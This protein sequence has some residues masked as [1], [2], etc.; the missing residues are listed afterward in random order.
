MAERG[1]PEVRLWKAGL[2]ER[3]QQLQPL[4]L[5]RSPAHSQVSFQS[6]ASSDQ[7][8]GFDLPSTRSSRGCSHVMTKCSCWCILRKEDWKLLRRRLFTSECGLRWIGKISLGYSSFAEIAEKQ[9]YIRQGHFSSIKTEHFS[10]WLLF[11][12][13]VNSNVLLCTPWSH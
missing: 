6:G 10:C 11:D 5:P 9:H 7:C 4:E 12:Y 1:V 2:G 13:I 8:L 3:G